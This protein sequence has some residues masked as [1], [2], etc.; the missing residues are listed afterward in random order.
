MDEENIIKKKNNISHSRHHHIKSDIEKKVLL[1]DNEEIIPTKKKMKRTFS[2]KEIFRFSFGFAILVLALF[3]VSYSYFN[4][5][6]TDP[7]Q[8]NISSGDVYVKLVENSTTITLNNLYPRENVEARSRND[9]YFD[10]TIKGK[11]TS[12]TK[13]I[14]YSI[15]INNGENVSGKT[16]IDPKYVRVD[17][18]EKVSN[19]YVYLSE[20][21]NLDNY[22]FKGMIPVNTT[23]EIT[24]EYRLRIWIN[25]E[26]LVSDTDPNATHTEQEFN[27]LFAT[28][29]VTIESE[30]K[31]YIPPLSETIEE[32][33]SSVNY[34]ASYDDV[35]DTNSTYKTQDQVSTNATKETVYYYTGSNAAANANVL[36]A[37][38]CWQ[39]I[40]TTDN[41][42]I[43]L[44]YNGVPV[45]NQCETNRGVTKGINGLNGT[46]QVMSGATLFGRNYDYNLNTGEFT[47][48]NSVSLPTTW[49][50]NDNNSN[51]IADYKEL[52]G[53]YTCLSSSNTCTTLYYVGS[54]YSP[55][56]ANVSKYTIGNVSHYSEIGTSAFNSSNASL[57]FVGYMFN[58]QYDFKNGTK[59][60]E[61]YESA[62]WENGAY[63]LSN[64]NSGTTPDVTHHYI[65]DTTCNKIRYYYYSSNYYILLENGETIEDAIYKMT[66]YGTNATQTK[67]INVG[68]E[69]NKY[70]SSIKGYLDNWYAKN[71]I[72]YT[73]YIDDKV[74]Y[75]NDRGIS[76]LGGWNPSGNNLI[77]TLGFNQTN[78]NANL[79]CANETDRF[80][81]T[82]PKAKLTYPIG[83]LTEPERNLM[84]TDFANTG[85]YYW[86]S[87]PKGFSNV[88]ALV[89]YVHNT[90]ASTFNNANNSYGVRPVISIKPDAELSS[91]T[92]TYTNPYVIGPIVQR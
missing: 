57:A 21:V 60:G 23:N 33:A 46:T 54:Y 25:D 3:G 32:K 34:I 16:R 70:N 56:T 36:F 44:I 74:V 59:S 92:G 14:Y 1:I 41:G 72:A 53:T 27:N 79:N 17:L 45:N 55:T 85:Q 29:N 51:G 26:I 13:A 43:R 81:V 39:I 22:S 71:L 4:Y 38:Y 80:S 24:K 83:L 73:S 31:V 90:G 6:R 15:V 89:R 76:D 12:P 78:P 65:C 10:L 37:G 7:R 11:N 88:N 91:G 35:I 47:I 86:T 30:E 67:S 9:N 40:R 2:P 63:I 48:G 18:Q 50:T 77:G 58:E 49:T 66:G 61:Y 87:S 84:T 62:V 52:I 69:L 28:F 75:C 20:G 5:K 82:N 42:G 8:A 19:E 68:Y 64:G